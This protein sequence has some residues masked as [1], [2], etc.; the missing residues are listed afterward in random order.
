MLEDIRF[1]IPLWP[2]LSPEEIENELFPFLDECG[3]IISDLYFTS[4]I[5][6]FSSDAMGGII[7]PEERTTVINN[8]L[9]ISNTF[10]I[11][12]SATFNDI[13]LSPSIKNYQTFVTNFRKLSFI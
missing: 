1:S 9:V 12:L 11:P 7:V 8:A 6:P 3:H 2:G 13:T 4:R 5:P 10:N